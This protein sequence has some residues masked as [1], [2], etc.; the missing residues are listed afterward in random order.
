MEAHPEADEGTL[1]KFRAT[2]VDESGLCRVALGLRLGEYI[3]LGKGEEQ[4]G[5]REKT[6]ILAGAVEAL[7]GA[8]Y[9]DAGFDRTME[10]VREL[11]S[12]FLELAGTDVMAQDHK[13]L[14]QEFTQHA[15]K[16]LPNYRLVEETGPP[17]D[18]VF[19]VEVHV[20]GKTLAEGEG[21]S[22]KEAEQRAAREA[23]A[24]LRGA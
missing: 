12:A 7:L 3:L 2:L 9:L 5:G 21:K 4:S 23:F 13:S 18:K 22:K 15:Y 6:S 17:H 8:L 14:L 19:R 10:I 11:F 24:C 16:C 20:G 1:S